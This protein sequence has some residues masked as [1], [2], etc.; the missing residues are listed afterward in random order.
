MSKK[1]TRTARSSARALIAEVRD[2]CTRHHIPPTEV[3]CESGYTNSARLLAG[4]TLNLTHENE[5]RLRRWL[6]SRR[7][8]E[9]ADTETDPVPDP[10]PA[11]GLLVLTRQWADPCWISRLPWPRWWST[12][13]PTSPARTSPGPLPRSRPG[14]HREPPP[15]AG[16]GGR[17]RSGHGRGR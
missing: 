6:E 17:G 4:Q 3:D 12:S 9:P 15:V 16:Q 1:I 2:F 14:T 10:A 13:G 5:S 8:P 11:P 7:F